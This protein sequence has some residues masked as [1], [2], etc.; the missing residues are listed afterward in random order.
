VCPTGYVRMESIGD[1]RIIW[2]KVFTMVA[3]SVCGRRF[4]PED[5]LKYISR[6][7]NVPFERLK[8]CTDCR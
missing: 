2:N 8:V 1:K 6:Q 4:A 3:C 7:T 5:Q